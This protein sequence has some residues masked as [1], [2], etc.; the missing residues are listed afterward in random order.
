[1]SLESEVERLTAEVGLYQ[2]TL[3][4]AL[5]WLRR[6]GPEDLGTAFAIKIAS[7][8]LKNALALQGTEPL[9]VSAQVGFDRPLHYVEVIS[10]E[11]EVPQRLYFNEKWR[12]DSCA[13]LLSGLRVK[14]A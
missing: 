9:I 5:Y 11:G 10:R 14:P 8:V 12:A 6:N 2:Q 7:D 13:L 4:L 3:R 1:M